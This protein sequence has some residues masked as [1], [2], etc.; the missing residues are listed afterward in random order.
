MA[1]MNQVTTLYDLPLEIA[2]DKLDANANYMIRVA[3]TGR[4]RSRM[5]MTADGI[6]VHDFMKTG[7]QPIYEFPIPEEALKDGKVVF[8]WTCG[9]AERGAQVSEIWIMKR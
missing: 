9:E 7:I 6:L 8:S 3:Y 4:F 1:W 5:K 2:Y